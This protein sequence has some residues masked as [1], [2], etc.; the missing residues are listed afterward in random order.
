MATPQRRPATSPQRRRGPLAESIV[1]LAG[2]PDDE[3]EIQSRLVAI[4]QLTAQM[5]SPVSYA[6]VTALRDDAY[7]TV[8]TSS[9]VALA[10]DSA[11]YADHAG[12][13][14]D[15]IDTGIPVDVPDIAMTLA[16]PGFQEQAYKLGLR[17]S[18]SIPL[19]A[20]S[21]EPI[22]ALNL[23]GHDPATMAPLIAHVGSVYDLSRPPPGTEGS[24][25]LDQGGQE[26]VTGLTDAFAVRALIHRAIGVIMAS[27]DHPADQAYLILRLRAADTGASLPDAAAA[28]IRTP[29]HR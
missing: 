17:A 19:F 29:P 8:A 25:A 11:Q 15:A 20:G 4:A 28:V 16:W 1:T 10:I 26:L 18:L 7:T 23:Y 13:C 22:A 12:P 2:M 21:G 24:Q 5:V 6:S 27:E 3:S 9:Y 14:L